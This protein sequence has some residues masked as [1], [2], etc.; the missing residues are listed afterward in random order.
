MSHIRCSELILFITENVY[1]LTYE[2][3]D[4]ENVTDAH[5]GILLNHKKGGNIAICDNMDKS[6]RHYAD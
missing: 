6:G 1:P 4:G 2:G 5:H 3:R